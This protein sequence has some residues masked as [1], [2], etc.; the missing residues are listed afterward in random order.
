MTPDGG[1][2]LAHSVRSPITLVLA[3]VVAACATVPSVGYADAVTE[4]GRAYEEE[5]TGLQRKLE[6]E[7]QRE[8]DLLRRDVDP[9][10]ADQVARFASEAVAI[11]AARTSAFFA[12]VGDALDRYRSGLTD[13]T[14]PAEVARAHH[15]L[16]AAMDSVLGGLP[17]LL[18]GLRRAEDFDAIDR[19]VNASVFTDA[20]PR[21][22]AACLALQDALGAGGESVDLRCPAA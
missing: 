17:E 9:D 2:R 7:L 14:P 13:L 19:A 22:R 18:D 21:L 3:I 5:A 8:I 1:F 16:V 11:T 4:L 6:A 15:E 12:S 20:G 10:D